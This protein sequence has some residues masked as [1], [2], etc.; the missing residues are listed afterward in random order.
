MG[1]W[2]TKWNANNYLDIVSRIEEKLEDSNWKIRVI[3]K[4][5]LDVMGKLPIGY[6]MKL[7]D[8]FRTK[9]FNPYAIE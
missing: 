8:R 1:D 2:I 4:D 9:M 6:S 7:S 5:V 3:A